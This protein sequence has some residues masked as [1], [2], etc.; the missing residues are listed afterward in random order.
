MFEAFV[1]MIIWT[2]TGYMQTMS[3]ERFNTIEE[4][5]AAKAAIVDSYSE[6]WSAIPAGDIRCIEVKSK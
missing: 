2:G 1:V 3:M 6:D 4:C 5:E